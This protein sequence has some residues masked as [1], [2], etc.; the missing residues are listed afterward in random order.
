MKFVLITLL[1]FSMPIQSAMIN[2]D[3]NP[4]KEAKTTSRN[5]NSSHPPE[6]KLFDVKNLSPGEIIMVVAFFFMLFLIE[7]PYFLFFL[8][9][10]VF[11]LV[12]KLVGIGGKKERKLAKDKESFYNMINNFN[13]KKRELLA[14]NKRLAKFL[15]SER[16]DRNYKTIG[17]PK[18][19]VEKLTR[20]YLK[21]FYDL[22]GNKWSDKIKKIVHQVFNNKEK[23]M[24]LAEDMI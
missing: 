9:P 24:Q 4:A 5:R 16:I 14:I 17:D 6:R 11:G 12:K 19:N 1:I 8:A 7:K 22:K 23:L 13:P 15:K 20:K 2:I 21:Q 3:S 18:K 10:F